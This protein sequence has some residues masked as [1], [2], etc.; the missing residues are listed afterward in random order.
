MA[1]E[2]D[3]YKILNVP[4]NASLEE[5]K[6]AYRKLALQYHPDKNPNN[7][8]AEEKFKEIN[9]AYEVL[10]DPQKREIYD[11][12]GEA[13]VKA[14][15]GV[16]AGGPQTGAGVGFEDFF[17]NFEVNEDFFGF[18]DVFEDLFGFGRSARK[19]TRNQ[20]EKGEDIYSS[21]RITLEEA[22]RGTEKVIEIKRRETCS[23]CNGSGMEP[24]SSKVV[25][26]Q[27]KG[28]GTLRKSQLFM[29]FTT[30]CPNCQGTGKIIKKPC[31]QCRGS[32]ITGKLRH[33]KI[34][35][36]RGIKDETT[37]RIPQ[38]GHQ[39]RWGG[40]VGDLY[41]KINIEPDKNFIREGANL[42]YTAEIPFYQAILGGEIN[43]NTFDEKL[44]VKIPAG[45]QSGEILRLKNKG[46]PVFQSPQERGDLLIK[47]K[48]K[49]PTHLT[50]EQKEL[51]EKFAHIS[52]KG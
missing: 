26:P 51:I 37:L 50:R 21:V 27:C 47:I 29:S 10:G 23:R 42:I 3:Y 24:G 31:Y 48:I 36:P 6:K 19:T 12:Y 39:G 49:I 2:K 25:C 9:E 34:E 7:K 18:T 28:S 44:K 16:G 1:E 33:I 5:I 22:Y 43:I 35:I 20:G 8:Q 17:R 4:R 38:G 13:G 32:G 46:M 40:S 11:K 15:A 41:I 45:V 30:V 14:G 52:Q